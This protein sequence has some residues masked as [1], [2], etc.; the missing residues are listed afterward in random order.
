MSAPSCS[1]FSFC[2]LLLVSSS[3]FF[4][5]FPSC[6]LFF[7]FSPTCL[8][9]PF[10]LSALLS[11]FSLHFAFLLRHSTSLLFSLFS[12]FS[13]CF[14]FPT[15]RHCV[16]PLRSLCSLHFG[17]SYSSSLHDTSVCSCLFLPFSCRVILLVSSRSPLVPSC[18]SF[19]FFFGFFSLPLSA[20]FSFLSVF[21]CSSLLHVHSLVIV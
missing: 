3:R 20:P 4:C 16:C 19:S 9:F 13:L 2:L 10:L 15:S 11:S 14:L 6:S 12:S 18:F 17:F 21:S 7:S 1:F 8:F 5:L